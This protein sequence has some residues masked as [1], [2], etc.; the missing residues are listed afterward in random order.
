MP[1]G[2][3]RATVTLIKKITIEEG[4]DLRPPLMPSGECSGWNPGG[5]SMADEERSGWNPGGASMV[6][7][8][9]SGWNPGGASMAR[10]VGAESEQM[11]EQM[12]VKP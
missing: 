6:D 3:L 4:E 8:E 7:E 2:E 11:G 9:R 5:A 10:W 1:S 12:R